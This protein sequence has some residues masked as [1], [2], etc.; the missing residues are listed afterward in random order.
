MGEVPR[1]LR[2]IEAVATSTWKHQTYDLFGHFECKAFPGQRLGQRH[3]VSLKTL[4]LLLCDYGTRVVRGAICEDYSADS[5]LEALRTLW[6]STGLSTHLTFDA[7]SNLSAAGSIFGGVEEDA[8]RTHL[9]NDQLIGTLGH[10]MDLFLL[11]V[12]LMSW[13]T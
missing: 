13:V 8:E 5:V 6:A 10:L 1:G 2:G 3:A 12:Q 4:A 7:A 9:L 11:W